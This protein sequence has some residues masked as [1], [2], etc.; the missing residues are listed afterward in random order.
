MSRITEVNIKW[1]DGNY[2][3]LN[4][5]A[6]EENTRILFSAPFGAGKSTFLKQFF[7]AY[8][9][10]YTTMTLCPVNYSLANN[11]D[12]FELMKFDILTE[13]IVHHQE[14]LP[15]IQ[16][17]EFALAL[18]VNA[19]LNS[20]NG[21]TG[22]VK[23]LIS[24]T[25]ELG[26][27]AITVLES[28]E[29]LK[30]DFSKFSTNIS[31]KEKK[32]INDFVKEMQ[33]A[34]GSPYEMDDVS[35][36]ITKCINDLNSNQLETEC[37]LIIE[38]LDRLDPE[39]IF[40]LF[41]IFSAHFGQEDGQNKFGFDRVIF[42]CDIHNIHRM[43]I[44]KYGAGVDFTGYMNKFYSSEPYEFDCRK[45]LKKAV[46]EL[47]AGNPWEMDHSLK[48]KFNKGYFRQLLKSLLT[49]FIIENICT[50]RM[51]DQAPTYKL[52]HEETFQDT[53]GSAKGY[54][55]FFF[56]FIILID[57]LRSLYPDL[58]T[59]ESHFKTLANKFSREY[60]PLDILE[61]SPELLHRYIASI[62]LEFLL[63]VKT[64]FN[65]EFPPDD[66]IKIYPYEDVFIHYRLDL[67]NTKP[68]YRYPKVIRIT[69]DNEADS[70]QI[71]S[72]NVHK[73]LHDTLKRCLENGYIMK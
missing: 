17:E 51:L 4:H 55:K 36:M 49:I 60:H 54:R 15:S 6:R 66:D 28:L 35:T 25:G 13:L 70:R 10:K 53:T 37:I 3:F 24:S 32:T 61:R 12:I 68:P 47:L 62:C 46:G 50:L 52:S 30:I 29:K 65:D 9:D 7:E 57:F 23:K 14:Q 1:E 31:E 34:K 19:Y 22:F 58:N 39:H 21:L 63:P 72:L 44:H 16:P 38:D 42:V 41:N 40:R 64:I 67:S 5:L 59:L 71:S 18:R 43:Y 69:S 48:E 33:S 27:S 26:K 11:Q 73:I 45:Y 8:P 20:P 56:D 2:D